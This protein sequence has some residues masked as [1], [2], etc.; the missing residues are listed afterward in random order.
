VNWDFTEFFARLGRIAHQRP[1]AL[2]LPSVFKVAGAHLAEK[3]A[4]S[5][6]REPDLPAAD[7]EMGEH[8]FFIDSSKAQRVLGFAPR[9][10]VET[11][12]DTVRYVRA[13][14]LPDDRARSVPSAR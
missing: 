12:T 7:V 3:W 13:A 2:R 4:R 1:P 14:F 10:P 9:D 11:L 6:G 8:W 5:R